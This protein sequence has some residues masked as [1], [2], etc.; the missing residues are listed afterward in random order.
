[1]REVGYFEIDFRSIA[2]F[3]IAIGILMIADSI[4]RL[5]LQPVY[6]SDSGVY[7]LVLA[8]SELQE[9]SRGGFFWSFCFVNASDLFQILILVSYGTGGVLIALGVSSIWV[10]IA[11]WILLCSVQVRNPHLGNA[12]DTL[13]RL[14]LFWSLFIPFEKSPYS[15]FQSSISKQSSLTLVGG[16][17]AGLMLQVAFVYLFSCLIKGDPVWRLDGVAMERALK[18]ESFA[19]P[20]AEV[21]LQRPELLKVLCKVTIVLQEVAPFLV[22]SPVYRSAL[23]VVVPFLMI[24]F[25]L[26]GIGMVLAIGLFPFISAA[27]WLIFFP[28]AFWDFGLRWV[29]RIRSSVSLDMSG[30]L[31]SVPTSKPVNLVVMVLLVYVFLWNL[32]SVSMRFFS[33]FSSDYFRA[34]GYILRINQ[35]WTLFAPRPRTRDGWYVSVARLDDGSIV[36]LIQK[37]NVVT[38]EKPASI[39]Q[40]YGGM[41]SRKYLLEMFHG[42]SSRRLDHYSDY[43]VG[44]WNKKHPGNKV[45]DHELFFML[46]D[47]LYPEDGIVRIKVH[48]ISKFDDRGRP[49]FPEDFRRFPKK[50]EVAEDLKEGESLL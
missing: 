35:Q 24:G 17:A 32:P 13:L 12:G 18:L 29:R 33:A 42:R 6:L 10:R 45:V 14:Y 37:G 50:G 16:R 31:A 49:V 21:I 3:R 38:W 15:L 48:P 47:S 19:L 46:K 44:D 20:F 8:L 1:M 2:A 5:N 36:D 7:P 22:F 34:P 40:F 9:S 30:V 4:G 11:V 26:I 27:G 28:P 25:H 39:R 41:R 23:R 43:L